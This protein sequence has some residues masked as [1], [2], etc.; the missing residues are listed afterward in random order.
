ML[1]RSQQAEKAHLALMQLHQLRDC[2]RQG[3]LP[4]WE[5]SYQRKW[6]IFLVQN[7]LKIAPNVFSNRFLSFQSEEIAR[8]FLNNFK[9]FIETAGDL[10]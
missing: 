9:G 1:F 6:I 7:E 8:K 10:I 2:Y 3:W 4:D 5:N